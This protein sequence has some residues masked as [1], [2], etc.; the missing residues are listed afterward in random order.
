MSPSQHHP[1]SFGGLLGSRAI[2]PV[3]SKVHHALP[4]ATRRNE[5]RFR[6]GAYTPKEFIREIAILLESVIVQLG[7]DEPGDADSRAILMDG[8]RSSLSHEG[9]EATLHLSDWNSE[10]P[11]DLTRHIL[12][13]GKAL[14][15]YASESN[16]AV[17]GDPSL[18]LY[19][20]CEGH[21]WVPPAGRL[22]RSHR[23]S[24][25]LMML[26]NEWL[27]QIT[28][29]RD[30]LIGFDNFE[31]VV[32]NLDDTARR[33]TRR[34]EDVR[35]ALLER[36]IRGEVS[37]ETFL[38]TAKVLTAPDLAPGG[39]GFQYEKGVVLPAALFSEI[40]PS[41]LLHFTP[42][43]LVE[44]RSPRSVLFVPASEKADVSVLKASSL[45]QV[46][47]Q[48]SITA[49]NAQ[50]GDPDPVL[51]I[52]LGSV[53][54][55]LDNATNASPAEEAEILASSDRIYEASEVLLAGSH[56]VTSS[57]PGTAVIR[58]T[59][60]V[61]L[62]ALLGELQPEGD[63][64]LIPLAFTNLSVS[65]PDP[66]LVT[67]KTLPRAILNTFGPDQ[68][69]WLVRN[70]FRPLGITPPPPHKTILHS[71]TGLVRPGEML[72]VL[73]RPGSGCS[74]FL[75]AAANRSALKLTGNLQFAGLEHGEFARKHRRE[76]LYLP[77]EDK[78]I[79]TL[80][81]R[82]TLEFALRMGMD[83]RERRERDIKRL[84]V[85]MA[86]MFGLE[87]ALDTIVGGGPVRGVSGGERKRVSIAEVLASG[88]SVQC[89][90]NSTR[91]LDSSTALDFVKALRTLTDVSQ[92]TTLATLYQAGESIYQHFDKVILLDSG[93]E[94][95]FGPI[96]EAKPYFEELGFVCDPG[97]TTAE[98]L[99][100]VTDPARRRIR[101]GS[102]GAS[103]QAL[104]DLARAFRDSAVFARLQSD[105]RELRESYVSQPDLVPTS[106]IELSYPE[107][108][109]GCLRR[110]VQLINGRR[111]VYYQK[112][113]NTVVL[114]LIVGSEYF[115]I[116]SDASGYPELFDAH[117][118]RAVLERQSSVNM[119]RSSA[120]ALA[121]ILIDIPM[122][123]LQHAFFMIAYYFLAHNTGAYTAG[124]FFYFYFVLCLSTINFANL[125][126]MFAYY[127][128]N[129]E[130]C[131]R[132]GGIAST[133]TVYFAGFLIPINRMRPVWSWLHYISPPRYA[134]EALLANEFHHLEI[135]CDSQLIPNVPGASITN[136]ICPI[137]GAKAGQH[138]VPGHQYV[139]FVGFSYANR[140]RNV[141]ILIALATAYML[142]GIV[143]SEA[144]QFT[145]Q[146]GAPIVFS[147]KSKKTAE[148][149]SNADVEKSAGVQDSSSSGTA[150][151]RGRPSLVWSDVTVDIGDKR[152]LHGITGY[153]R[154]GELVALCGSSG[155][156][157]TTLLTHLSQT[158]PA[159][160]MGGQLEF[161]NK[162]LG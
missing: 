155:A 124:D 157:K 82:Q 14:F 58:A 128:P 98:F 59:T 13:I 117:A 48:I 116:S 159:G 54:R 49:E 70:I 77:E 134:Y 2:G 142:V 87:H 89:F 148:A 23:S 40:A 154:P 160:V 15:Q 126:R 57:A 104:E 37:R 129:L 141:G 145:V 137:R 109:W 64:K 133:T 43:R 114:C 12:R 84:V 45:S 80:T 17:A 61:D 147:H 79:L 44:E 67:A 28:C 62:L 156:G 34:M 51:S 91:G 151:Y 118:N 63:P 83:R 8:L 19:S 122:I 66:G 111:G 60:E 85:E 39:Y 140:W 131:F 135:S 41:F 161:G 71:F 25:I 27:H 56:A 31:H 120:V 33:G 125:L 52:D 113:I 6:P 146:G 73:G 110:E 95:F 46:S 36:V 50:S 143:G 88:S 121:R 76:T 5:W 101:P 139:E 158:N 30:Y 26:Y 103:L 78:H 69:A 1:S 7:P 81:V 38:E 152:I 107:Q 21:K 32:L 105:L 138:S 42:T 53:I 3:D 29:L 22:L 75:R 94:I 97:Q 47:W 153:V 112:W 18:T 11:S 24:P 108:I 132:F 68:V 136:Q 119:Y 106:P 90:D 16:H 99:T 72:L 149:T 150:S 162:P 10:H 130:D 65:A 4:P 93:H 144:M 127:V 9:R 96:G 102:A 115:S 74:T 55:G 92:K 123:A 86:R 35:V 100:S 20:P